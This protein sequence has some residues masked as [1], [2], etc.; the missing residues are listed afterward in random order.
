MERKDLSIK[1]ENFEECDL[2]SS[3]LQDSIFHISF[4]SFHEE[5]KCFRLMLNR[6]CWESA[7]SFEKNKC[8]HRVHSGLYIYH[9]SSV[10]A[11]NNIIRDQY[12]SLL[13]IHASQNEINL[14]FSENKHICVRVDNLLI[15]LK[16]LHDKYSTLSIPIH[17]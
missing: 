13:T 1:A 7:D 2:I 3:F 8:Y 15:Y 4:H 14:I 17:N 10:V 16:D 11:S 6:F 5:R 9:S 12:L